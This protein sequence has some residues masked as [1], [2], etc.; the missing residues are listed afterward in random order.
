MNFFVKFLLLSLSCSS[1]YLTKQNI[2]Q[3]LFTRVVLYGRIFLPFVQR[4]DRDVEERGLSEKYALKTRLGKKNTVNK[5][6]VVK[7]LNVL[8]WPKVRL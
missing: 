5:L 3:T 6:I 4:P 8:G 1:L 2:P 7:S